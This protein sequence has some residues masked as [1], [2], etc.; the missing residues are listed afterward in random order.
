MV[1]NAPIKITNDQDLVYLSGFTVYQ[2]PEIRKELKVNGNRYYVVN[3]T[4]D[5]PAR[6]GL[7]AITVKDL[8]TNDIS[9][10]YEGTQSEEGDLDLKTDIDLVKW[11]CDKQAIQKWSKTW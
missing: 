2:H 9:I 11:R 7:D 10:I 5:I 4:Y 6:H 1:V 8:Q 3:R